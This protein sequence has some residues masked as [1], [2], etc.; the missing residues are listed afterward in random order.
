[1]ETF[2]KSSIRKNR[3]S[4]ICIG[5]T[6][7]FNVN[8]CL[9]DSINRQF[10]KLTVFFNLF[11]LIYV[12]ICGRIEKMPILKL[13]MFKYC[14]LLSIVLLTFQVAA[15]D[16]H[17]SQIKFSPLTVNPANAGLNGKY[18]AIANYRSQWNSVADPFTTV[19]ASFD[20][21]FGR[22]YNRKGFLAAGINFFHDI[23]GNQKMTT[24][25]VNLSVSYHIRLNSEN[26]LGLG[27]QGGYAQRGLGNADGVFASQYD[28]NSFDPS[29]ASGESFKRMNF[30]YFDAGGGLVFNHDNMTS[31]SF[32]SG[33]YK[34]TIGAAAYHLTQPEYGFLQGG[35][36]DL[37]IRYSGFVE[38]EFALKNPRFVIMPAL[39]YQRQG[40]FQE[41]YGGTYIKY[42]ITPPSRQT[43]LVNGFSIA[44][45]PFYRFGDSFVNCL[46][47]DYNG[48]ALG[49]SYD[50]NL[51]SLT[52]A[53][54]GRG[55]YEFMF[56]WT[57][58]ENHQTSAR[59]H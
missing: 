45:G 59:I 47:I 22:R 38:A 41:I 43:S 28:G 5:L 16:V 58:P 57:L 17:F 8:K 44:Y 34:L 20:M 31:G 26:T 46:L 51:S 25:N 4:I 30:G 3:K 32:N 10:L 40:T 42:Y 50:L 39:Y 36:D 52:Q 13:N 18:N 48:F 24:S 27:V 49:I 7:V 11:T 9:F 21:K 54:K 56:R 55:G 23:A 29:I 6:L 53:S 1:M 14:S 33:G 35:N 12:Y 37:A 2:K 19:G 15:Q